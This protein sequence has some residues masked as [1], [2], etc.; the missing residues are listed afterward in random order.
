MILDDRILKDNYKIKKLKH[1]VKQIRTGLNP[2]DNFSLGNGTIKYITAKNLT[3]N[4]MIDF[5]SCD[6]IEPEAKKIIHKR[7]DIQVGDILFSSRAPIGQSHII[8]EEPED[9][10][11]GESIFS[12]RV[13]KDILVP[14][15]LCL[16]FTSKLFIDSAS[17]NVT[18][19]VIKEIR[20]GD[21]LETEI[22]VP[23]KDKQKE[24]VKCIN[25]LDKKLQ[26][27]LSICDDLESMARQLYNYWFVQFDFPDDNGKPYKSSGGKMVW[28]E[29]LN[30][31]I[32]EGWVVKPVL[33][34]F[35]WIGTSQPP[36]STFVYE[37]KDG[38]VRF[39]QNRDYDTDAHLTYIPLTSNTHTCTDT[40]IMMDKYGDAGKTRYGIS[41]AYNVALSKIDVHDSNLRE[42][43]R[44]YLS[45]DTIYSYLHSACIA[46]TRASLNESNFDFLSIVIPETSVL[47][48][49][50]NIAILSIQHILN[51][52]NENKK[53]I[54][55]RDFLLPMLMNGQVK[56][57]KGAE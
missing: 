48:K 30:R 40:D 57:G 18:G 8:Q 2:R 50:N 5:S 25:I 11:I 35:D 10:D 54:E 9:Y 31:E 19:S 52:K 46:S 13:N 34:V 42:Y 33:D 28:N 17:H 43:V 15:Y 55:L 36:K 20:I 37:M 6:Y 26:Y 22:L 29:K 23:S 44:M 53:L 47:H 24:I 41:G 49:F 16:Y 32:P 4:G 56:V 38:Y 27:N 1:C 21:L 3:N 12:I 14:E 39:I 51:K 7:S 45:S